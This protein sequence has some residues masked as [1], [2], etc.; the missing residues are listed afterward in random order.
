MDIV[1]IKTIET[2]HWQHKRGTIGGIAT[3]IEDIEQ[4]LETIC[5]NA[6][7]SV[8]HN[9]NIGLP[10]LDYLDMPLNIVAPQ[11]RQIIKTELNYQEPRI[12]VENVNLEPDYE[13]ILLIKISYIYESVLREKEV[14]T[15]WL[16]A[17]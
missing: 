9:P 15:Q 10:I 6:K 2:E 16:T 4:C 1:N 8:I 14:K 17:A 3:K 13:G 5:T 12:T 7:G 11:L